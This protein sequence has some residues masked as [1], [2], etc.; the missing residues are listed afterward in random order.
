MKK[1]FLAIFTIIFAILFG[2]GGSAILFAKPFTVS[3]LT[4]E[5]PDF[6]ISQTFEYNL[7]YT[8]KYENSGYATVATVDARE[9]FATGGF[10]ANSKATDIAF[11]FW[12]APCFW[13][14][15][16]IG[17]SA[18]YH[19]YKFCD[20]GS[21]LF[22]EHTFLPGAFIRFNLNNVWN[23][24]VNSGALIKFAIIDAYPSNV[25]TTDNAVFLNTGC[26]FTP[27][28]RWRFFFEAGN[29]TLFEDDVV[30]A[31]LCNL[32]FTF[33]LFDYF[34]CG[35][36]LYFKWID[37]AVLN[38]SFSQLSVRMSFGVLF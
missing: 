7:M 6:S 29:C 3:F 36:E 31:I 32:G 25:R 1:R 17:V 35:P 22:C 14:L 21:E 5:R 27:T 15:V 26:I 11:A 38:D 28:D 19:Y 34:T 16:S 30:G 4:L 9:L 10:Y 20:E 23:L 2:R 33:R 24:Y 37:A 12:Y 8:S 18:K 13:D